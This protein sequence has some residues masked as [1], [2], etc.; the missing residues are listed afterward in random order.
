MEPRNPEPRTEPSSGT[1][2]R[3]RLRRP[4]ALAGILPVLSVLALLALSNAS[5]P[6]APG[7]YATLPAPL[8]HS[9]AAVPPNATWAWG[10]AANLSFGL[11]YVGAYNHSLNLTA[12]NLSMTGAYVAVNESA[13]IG[14]AAYAIVTAKSPTPSTR[15]VEVRAVEARELAFDLAAQ[16]TFPV[17]GTYGPTSA[18]PLANT[19]FGLAAKEVVVSAFVGYLNFTTNASAVALSNE[20]LRSFTG[21][22]VSL[23]AVNFPNVT[24]GANG[25]VVLSYKSGALSAHGY[26]A[27][28]LNASFLPALPVLELPLAVGKS[29]NASSV[30]T[31]TGR[32]VYD[33]VITAQLGSARVSQS[34]SGAA[35]L[36]ATGKID[37]AFRVTNST[38]VRFPDGSTEQDYV[39]TA[40][41]GGHSSPYSV[42]D[43]LLVVP[44]TDATHAA[45]VAPAVS[46]RPASAPLAAPS[47]PPTSAVVSPSRN[48]PVSVVARPNAG[49]A[50]QGA[51]MTPQAAEARIRHLGTPQPPAAPSTPGGL[52]FAGIV[53][54]T[55]IVVVVSTGTGYI[56]GR[57]RSRRDG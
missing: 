44:S 38:T 30:A 51:P 26:V 46:A 17:A 42:W 36:N 43:G 3:T 12:G 49:S 6:V 16:G 35:S 47:G 50:V 53:A 15:F 10:A 33:T 54:L 14:F 56:L 28:E 13:R 45:G 1:S 48:L 5:V 4:I 9:F 8:G 21:I 29:W 18:V 52:G 22:N 23:T 55:G 34:S 11:V 7:I 20:H 19:S 32:S 57:A 25:T 24:A 37:L 41:S 39:V 2:S 27:S 31:V 40:T